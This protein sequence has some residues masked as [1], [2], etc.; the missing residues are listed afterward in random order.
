MVLARLIL[1][2]VVLLSL[3]QRLLL[4]Q[5]VILVHLYNSDLLEIQAV[6]QH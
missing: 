3:K 2:V 6:Q 1:Q 4:V 5:I